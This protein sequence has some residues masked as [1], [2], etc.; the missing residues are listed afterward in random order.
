MQQ[1][2]K[3]KNKFIILKKKKHIK[4]NQRLFGIMK[5]I[6]LKVLEMHSLKIKNANISV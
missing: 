3:N 4:T 5:N 6:L 2:Q 1:Q